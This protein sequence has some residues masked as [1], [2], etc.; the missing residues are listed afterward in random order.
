[1][2]ENVFQ[3]YY[4]TIQKQTFLTIWPGQILEKAQTLEKATFTF[5]AILFNRLSHESENKN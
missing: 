5:S 1:M 4:T 2:P 3:D